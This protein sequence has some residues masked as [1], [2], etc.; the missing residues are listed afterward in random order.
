MGRVAKAEEEITRERTSPLV[1]E[2]EDQK[3]VLED[4]NAHLI[5]VLSELQKKLPQ[6]VALFPKRKVL[7]SRNAVTLLFTKYLRANVVLA[8]I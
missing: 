6:V 4:K 3:I 5:S 8:K 7:R 2:L 1:K